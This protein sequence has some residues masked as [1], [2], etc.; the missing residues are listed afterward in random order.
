[1]DSW[2]PLTFRSQEKEGSVMETKRRVKRAIFFLMVH[3]HMHN[4]RMMKMI[5]RKEEIDDAGEISKNVK[6]KV[7]EQASG[8]KM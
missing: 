3:K 1:M 5:W 8:G 7:P 2:V 4:F 6:N